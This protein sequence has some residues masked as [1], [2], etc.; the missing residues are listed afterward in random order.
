MEARLLA[1]SV[2]RTTLNPRPDGVSLVET[3]ETW[4]YEHRAH[5]ARERPAAA[6]RARYRISYELIRREGRFVVHRLV[7]H[8]LPPGEA[9]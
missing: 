1:S 4:S 8:E 3:V 9:P 6:K 5:G 7:D 2:T